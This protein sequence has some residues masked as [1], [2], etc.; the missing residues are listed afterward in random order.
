VRLLPLRDRPAPAP[1]GA[2]GAL[3]RA[4]LAEIA[5]RERAGEALFT[6]LRR[7]EGIEIATF[8]ARHGID[9]LA[10]FAEGLR[11]PMRAGLVEVRAGSLRLTTRGVLLSNE[12]FGAFV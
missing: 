11:D 5:A 8:R 10:A 7:R 3:P 9:P 12:V 1:R 6:G 4:L 2:I